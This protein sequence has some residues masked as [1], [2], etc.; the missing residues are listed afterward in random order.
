MRG[1]TFCRNN[2]SPLSLSLSLSLSLTHTHAH[3]QEI[4]RLNARIDFLSKQ[5]LQQSHQ[6]RI[7]VKVSLPVFPFH[8]PHCPEIISLRNQMLCVVT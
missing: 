5:L 1:Q 8:F 4:G 3:A 2:F 6:L 7:Q